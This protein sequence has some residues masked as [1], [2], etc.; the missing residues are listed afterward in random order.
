F[1][2][3]TFATLDA[4]D[5]RA[6]ARQAADAVLVTGLDYALDDDQCDRLLANIAAVLD[7][8][9][10]PNPRLVF[11]VRY[12][13]NLLTRVIDDV[14]LPLEARYR[15]RRNAPGRTIV[16]REKGY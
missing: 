5:G 9:A 8:S 12:R 7:R 1:P 16:R 2:D 3:I 14:V 13:D 6:V 15:L 4:L 10:R 11:T